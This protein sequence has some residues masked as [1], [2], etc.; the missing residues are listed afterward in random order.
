MG[1]SQG[2]A[3]DGTAHTAGQQ[4]DRVWLSPPDQAGSE[5]LLLAQAVASNWI[6][7][8]GPAL[9]EFE[10]AIAGVTG[11]PH[12]VA[13]SSGT[14]AL[15]LACHLA[16]VR[17][18]DRVWTST[19]TF[20]A[21]ITG[22]CHLGALPGFLDVDP[23]T[24]TLDPCLLEEALR[25]AA[26]QDRLPRAVIAVDL[27]GQPADL[28]RLGAACAA[29]GVTL[30]ADSA[31][32]FG[33]LQRGRHAGCGARLTAFSFNGN[34]ILTCGGGGALASPDAAL[35][36][37]ARHLATQAREPAPHYE[38]VELGY[39]FRLSNLLAAVGLAQLGDLERRVARRR[40]IFARYVEGLAP[41]PGIGFMPEADWARASRWLTVITVDAARFGATPEEIR[42]TL[43]AR[44]IESRPVWKPMH[45]QH[46]FR[47]A[48]RVG[49]RVA[50]SLFA[51]GLCLPSGSGMSDPQQDRVI[52][53][54]RT[55]HA[56][57]MAA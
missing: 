44:N 37:R 9:R 27:Y 32:G 18:G 49:G 26:R 5:L 8:A 45:L 36:E 23:A 28:A 13:L 43:E 50:E 42:A 29:H 54:I 47:D 4:P 31:E 16:G 22:A 33:A 20:V 48:F 35:I 55:L 25:E 39:N 1:S 34:K 19:L 7:P 30:I 21:S 3:V 11:I 46:V 57:R 10:A 38:H 53:A 51:R 24:W 12:V 15:H 2:G 14:A 56:R 52:E 40:R 6:A 17:P 41:L